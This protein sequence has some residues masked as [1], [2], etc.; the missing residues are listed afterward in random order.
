MFSETT[1]EPIDY[2]IRLLKKVSIVFI[3]VAIE[4]GLNL[5][6]PIWKDHFLAQLSMI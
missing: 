2:R 5:L 4:V 6:I 1:F 3:L